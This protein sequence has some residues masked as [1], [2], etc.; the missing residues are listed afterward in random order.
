VLKVTL[1]SQPRRRSGE[2]PQFG[3]LVDI[4]IVQD[5]H[6]RAVEAQRTT[7]RQPLRLDEFNLSN[8]QVAG[9]VDFGHRPPHCGFT[10]VPAGRHR[11]PGDHSRNGEPQ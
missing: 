9:A 8:P 3:G 10:H 1:K 5:E 2:L 6:D 7:A 11:G 4:E